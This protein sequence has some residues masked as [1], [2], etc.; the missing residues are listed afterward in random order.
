MNWLRNKWNGFFFEAAMPDNLGLARILVFGSMAI[1]YLTTPYLFPS[2]GWHQTFSEW[3]GVS[4]VFWQPI[5]LFRTLHLP[6]LSSGQITLMDAVWKLA[7]IFSAIGLFTRFS[8]AVAFILCVYLFGLQ[9]NFGKTHHLEVLLLWVFLIFT[10]SRCGDAWSIDRLIR[11]ARGDSAPPQKSGEYTWPIRLI[12]VVMCMIYFEAGVSKVRHSGLTWITG[13]VM[14]FFLQ[15]AQYHITD[16][17]PLSN[18][19]LWIARHEWSSELFALMGMGLELSYPLALF[20]KRLRWILV[21][22][23]MM[24]QIGIAV[25]MGPNFY[26]M[27]I[28][29]FLWLPLDKIV[30][31]FLSLF[32]G[33]KKYSIV[34]DGSCG[35]CN[36]TVAVVKS[37][38]LLHRVDILDCAHGWPE[39]HRRF[40][41]L[42]RD[43]CLETMHAVDSSGHIRTGFGAYRGLAYILPLGWVTLP[44]FY[45]PGASII[46]P[47]IYQAVAD[48]RHNS[49]CALPPPTIPST[50]VP[51]EA[52][53]K[54]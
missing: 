51:T 32:S 15:R 34:F 31:W 35:L 9:N 42:D 22:S 29:Q 25:L 17:E 45:L 19:G 3:G 43:Q 24:M 2:W 46:G 48:Q 14:S 40:P 44:L 47:R 18:W 4:H 37:L 30:Y 16:A 36:R 20:S 12:W 27:I 50:A 33:R 11:T 1:F 39:V 38:D 21:P 49:G 8:N 13:G 54:P 6:L 23:G 28:C 26:Q 5:W 10:V 52:S 41:Q 7:L 53:G